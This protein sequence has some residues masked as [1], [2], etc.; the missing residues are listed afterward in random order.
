MMTLDKECR[1]CKFWL[2]REEVS[3]SGANEVKKGL[4]HICGKFKVL[5]PITDDDFMQKAI[6]DTCR[7]YKDYMFTV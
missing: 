4:Y 3:I 5:I 7:Y 6:A 1:S 2:G